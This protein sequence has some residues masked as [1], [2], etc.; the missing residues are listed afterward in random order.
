MTVGEI[1]TFFNEHVPSRT[2]RQIK[3]L[4][5]CWAPAEPYQPPRRVSACP[6]IPRR[7]RPTH[8]SQPE[9]FLRKCFQMIAWL[10]RT[11]QPRCLLF[12]SPPAAQR[13]GCSWHTQ[14]S[15]GEAAPSAGGGTPCPRASPPRPHPHAA[16]GAAPTAASQQHR[17]RP[18]RDGA[19][20]PHG[21]AARQSIVNSCS[22]TRPTCLTL[23]INIVQ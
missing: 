7:L 4:R 9:A 23:K 5:L 3:A 19:Q 8:Q 20:T 18:E 2:F 6:V 12:E 22:S 21:T 15:G 13:G 17:R 11:A 1:R 16:R 10:S 14:C